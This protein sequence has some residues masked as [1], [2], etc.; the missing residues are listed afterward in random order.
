M[1]WPDETADL[2]AFYPTDLMATAFDIIFFW[3]AR[4]IMMGLKFTGRIPSAKFSSTAWSAIS[5]AGR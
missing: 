4:M 2:E 5:G 1:G 3:V